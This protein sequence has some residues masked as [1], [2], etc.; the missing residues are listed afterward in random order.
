M[1]AGRDPREIRHKLM[2]EVCFI[3]DVGILCKW[4]LVCSKC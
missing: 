2:K 3:A 4:L 1:V